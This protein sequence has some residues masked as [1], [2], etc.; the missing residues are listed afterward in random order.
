MQR[1]YAQRLAESPIDRSPEDIFAATV[2]NDT[3]PPSR[4]RV[5]AVVLSA[6]AAFSTC[7]LLVAFSARGQLFG[8]PLS[9]VGPPVMVSSLIDDL[10]SQVVVRQTVDETAALADLDE[11]RSRA[12]LVVDLST[13]TDV[14]VIPAGQNERAEAALVNELRAAQAL[15]GRSL[16]VQRRDLGRSP[17]TVQDLSSGALVVG[18]LIAALVSLGAGRGAHRVH[19]HATAVLALSLGAVAI[20]SALLAGWMAAVW[21]VMAVAM[22]VVLTLALEAL[23]GWTGFAAAAALCLTVVWP[24][25]LGVDHVFLPV[26]MQTGWHW[27]PTGSA[28]SA[29]LSAM[30]YGSAGLLHHGLQMMVWLVGGGLALWLAR[31]SPRR[32]NGQASVGRGRIGA[33]VAGFTVLLLGAVALAPGSVVAD[34]SSAPLA[35]NRLSPCTRTPEVDSVADLNRIAS[36]PGNA[37]FAGADVGTDVTLSDGRRLWLFGD[38]LRENAGL[39]RNSM[40]VADDRCLYAVVPA[41]GGAVIPDRPQSQVGYW[42]MSVAAISRPGYDLVPVWAERVRQLGSGVFDFETLGPS[43]ALFVVRPGDVPQLVA[44]KDLTP[45]T[46]DV[47]QPVWG[48]ASAVDGDWVYLY[49]T[50]NAGDTW[51]FSV[52]VA[53]L[54]VDDLLEPTHMQYWDGFDWS[55]S[56][57]SAAQVIPAAGGTSQIFSVFQQDETWYAVSKQ[58]EFLGSYL[59]VWIATAPTGPFYAGPV[60]AILPSDLAAGHFT[61]MALAHPEVLPEDNSMVVSYSR[62]DVNLQHIVDDPVQ[63]RPRFLRVWFP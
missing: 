35:P 31:R 39:V 40:L 44:M 34:S 49:G 57:G 1:H 8:A 12:V 26:W 32:I 14:L 27:S 33:I 4:A 20:G 6:L 41:D 48:A 55:E 37:Y 45:D 22:A 13:T 47:Q 61:Y 54:H 51:G 59:R 52:Q 29:V 50:A 63:Y 30:V 5:Y 56:A 3:V 2:E 38:T 23:F 60:L 36:M 28:A 17:R 24:S 18:F 9:V 46:A 16:E 43:V 19:R 58:D 25:A 53:R 62:N 7:L 11:G 15:R 21:L 10:G 42:P